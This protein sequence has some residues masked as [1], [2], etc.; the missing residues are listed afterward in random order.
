M[1]SD[2]SACRTKFWKSVGRDLAET[3]RRADASHAIAVARLIAFV[4]R[5][6][7]RPP[8]Y[9]VN[10]TVIGCWVDGFCGYLV[11]GYFE[12]EKLAVAK[13]SKA[14]QPRNQAAAGRCG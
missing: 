5:L 9:A 6:K 13:A 10:H 4:C 14:I 1:R 2:V 3:H 12:A 7:R 8:V 11:A